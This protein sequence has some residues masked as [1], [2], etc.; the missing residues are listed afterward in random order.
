MIRSQCK[1]VNRGRL[2][3]SLSCFERD[4]RRL[5]LRSSG[6]DGDRN[7]CTKIEPVNS[8]DLFSPKNLLQDPDMYQTENI[9]HHVRETRVH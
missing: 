4:N 8:V 9:H 7:S 3:F 6:E 1:A 5:L 2:F